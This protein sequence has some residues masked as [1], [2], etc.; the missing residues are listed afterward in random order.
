M[1]KNI[2]IILL[3]FGLIASAQQKKLV[4]KNLTIGEA[5]PNLF[6]PKII[7]GK[8]ANARLHD[9]ND[10]LLII[11]FWATNCGGC[12]AALPRMEALQKQFGNKI[13]ILPVTYEGAQ[14]VTKFLKQN[15]YVK[16]L[17]LESVVEDEVLSA[18][19]KHIGVPHEVWIY[20]GKVIGLTGADYVDAHNIQLVLNGIKNDWPVKNDFLPPYDYNKPLLQ[21]KPN[22]KDQF[23][24]AAMFG[25]LEGIET[26][27]G[28]VKDSVKHTIRNY[29]TNSPIL[30]AYLVLWH[31]ANP[32]FN[33]RPFPSYIL[34]EVKNSLK[35]Q[36]DPKQGYRASWLRKYA[37]SY[38]SLNPDTGQTKSEQYYA[39]I[40]DL[41]HLLGLKGRWEIRKTK[42]LLLVRNNTGVNIK[43]AGAEPDYGYEGNGPVIKLRNVSIAVITDFLNRQNGNLPAID[44]TH[45]TDKIDMDL[46]VPD[47]RDLNAVRQ[48]LFPYGLELK[49]EMKDIKVFVLTEKMSSEPI[50]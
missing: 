15:K 32:D 44:D 10:R 30:T 3:S 16:D 48:A 39:A 40:S 31:Y 41:D 19:F 24:Y 12:V 13:K 36:F 7:N 20:K 1:K 2:L 18:S 26:N 8:K 37:I 34:W 25:Y 21:L 35:Y 23:K 42:C 6:I 49:E 14:L 46:N 4:V 38:E 43:S 33:A 50:R 45:Y 22:Q 28:S 27:W 11:D 5:V 29:V 17:T 47:W 9:F